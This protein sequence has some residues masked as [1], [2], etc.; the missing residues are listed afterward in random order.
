MPFPAIQKRFR[1]R[2]RGSGLVSSVRI[3]RTRFNK[4]Q[5]KTSIAKTSVGKGKGF[6]M[7][8]FVA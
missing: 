1:L 5:S 6:A 4:A 8:Q 3:G 2:D 7:R